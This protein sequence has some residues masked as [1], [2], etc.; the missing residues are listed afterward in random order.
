MYVIAGKHRGRRIE[1][2]EGR[3]IRPTA[4]RTR[5]A[6]FNILSHGRYAGE[7]PLLQ[8]YVADIFCGSGAMGLEAFSRGAAGVTFVDKSKESLEAAEYNL[9]HFGEQ[10]RARLIRAD[11]SMLPPAP[12]PHDILFIDPPYNTGLATGA[13]NTARSGGWLKPEGV[14]V[15]EQAIKEDAIIPEGWEELDNRK[16]GNTRILILRQSG[17]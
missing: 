5:E 10:P 1:A 12:M 7:N 16:Y 9:R 15:V 17:S 14:A 8:G 3:A 13:L 11:S 2:P 4:S 6:V